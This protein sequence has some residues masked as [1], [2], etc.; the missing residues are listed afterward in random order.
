MR[1]H[2][3]EGKEPARMASNHPEKKEEGGEGESQGSASSLVRGNART[4]IRRGQR[5]EKDSF[6]AER[7]KEERGEERVF[8]LRPI[9]GFQERGREICSSG[10]PTLQQGGGGG[11]RVR[12]RGIV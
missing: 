4:C 1:I 5:C 10:S 3:V 12:G 8:S 9:Y 2:I 6:L 11:E 7:G